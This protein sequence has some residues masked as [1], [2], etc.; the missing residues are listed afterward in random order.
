[1]KPDDLTEAEWKWEK[2]IGNVGIGIVV[3]ALLLA[4]VLLIN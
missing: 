4:I 2:R 1:M 3:I